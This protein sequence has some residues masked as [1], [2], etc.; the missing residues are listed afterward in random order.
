MRI[1]HDNQEI[2][3]TLATPHD[4]MRVCRIRSLALSQKLFRSENKLTADIFEKKALSQSHIF[5]DVLSHTDIFPYIARVPSFDTDWP[6]ERHDGYQDAGYVELNYNTQELRIGWINSVK[7]PYPTGSAMLGVAIHRA[8]TDKHPQIGTNAAY[9][10]S[11]KWF[12][13]NGLFDNYDPNDG[14]PQSLVL[15]ASRYDNALNNIEEKRN[16][17]FVLSP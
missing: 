12:F 7:S 14:M 9:P 4:V 3:V 15:H 6:L 1:F 10:E 8:R 2:F 5:N 13:E 17:R 11:A 16:L